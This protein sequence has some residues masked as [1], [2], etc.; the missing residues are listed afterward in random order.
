MDQTTALYS[1]KFLQLAKFALPPSFGETAQATGET[2]LPLLP[3]TAGERSASSVTEFIAA[4]G[5]RGQ[6]L[7][8]FVNCTQNGM[9]PVQMLQS[10][11][12]H[13]VELAWNSNP[14]QVPSAST[15]AT[16][17]LGAIKAM[18]P[19][20]SKGIWDHFVSS[21]QFIWCQRCGSLQSMFSFN[22]YSARTN[23][24]AYIFFKG[25]IKYVKNWILSCKYVWKLYPK[26]AYLP[27]GFSDFLHFTQKTFEQKLAWHYSILWKIY[28]KY[29]KK[30]SCS[31]EYKQC[32]EVKQ[33]HFIYLWNSLHKSVHVIMM[34]WKLYT[35]YSGLIVNMYMLAAFS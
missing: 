29:W 11:T 13:P 14:L 31:F 1:R 26:N 3:R 30:H 21:C 7:D 25:K 33:K 24:C 10:C 34:P 16:R 18:L 20:D 9:S 32:K 28:L 4:E 12:I 2:N 8:V 19:T 15:S 23:E 17:V 27:N 5:Q 35:F 6:A 22:I